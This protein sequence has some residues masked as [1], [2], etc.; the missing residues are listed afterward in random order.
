MITLV[1]GASGTQGNAV[2]RA[3]LDRGHAVRILARDPFAPAIAALTRMGAQ[4][5]TASFAQTDA[6]RAAMAGIDALFS[7]QPAPGAQPDSERD[8]AR[9]LVEAAREGGVRHVIHSSVSNTGTFRDMAGWAEGR[10]ARNYWESKADVEAMVRA[11]GFP[12]H[13]ILRPAFMMDNFALPKATWM[14]PD[15]AHGAI[16]TAVASDT[17]M[18]LV[19]AEDIGQAVV[20]AIERPET[21][22]GQAVELAGDLLTLPQIGAV[23]RA[24]KGA[25]VDVVTLDAKTLVAEGQNAGWVETQVWMNVVNYP[26]RPDEMRAWGLAPTRFEDW[27]RRHADI[28]HIGGV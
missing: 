15:L 16:R 6:L 26:A 19:A 25:D 13:T 11:A 17:P 7:M 9:A 4:A 18:I 23:L 24:V 12:V 8:Q 1:T 21:F 27:A 3:L 22:A 2:A 28:I 5:A 14:F 10:W 20:A